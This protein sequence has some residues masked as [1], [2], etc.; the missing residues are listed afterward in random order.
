MRG[1]PTGHRAPPTS[2]C[3]LDNKPH[4]S[5]VERPSSTCEGR[6]R[7]PVRLGAA[8]W[9][10]SS[11][12]CPCPA[13][14][15]APRPRSRRL[16]V[17]AVGLV[18][19]SVRAGPESGRAIGSS[20]S[21][22]SGLSGSASGTPSGP[23]DRRVTREI[24]TRPA[25]SPGNPRERLPGVR[26]RGSAGAGRD[27]AGSGTGSA[28]TSGRLPDQARGGRGPARVG[29]GLRNARSAQRNPPHLAPC[30]PSATKS[31]CARSARSHLA[32]CEPR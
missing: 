12:L 5:A 22:P 15:A 11:A 25:R 7:A 19:H 27:R 18:S 31:I 1:A 10:P 6:R 17:L 4:I 3:P 13:G 32:Q 28:T 26:A 2:P 23:R 30:E 16:A 8:R 20:S 24:V 29:S 21:S 14:R 9:T